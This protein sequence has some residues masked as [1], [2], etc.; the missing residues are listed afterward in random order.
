MRESMTTLL[1]DWH[2]AG[3]VSA[4]QV[5][6]IVRFERDRGGTEPSRRT[7][8]AEAVGYVG[9]AL[10]MGAI[11]LLVGEFW[12]QFTTLA[13]L[14]LV[15][16]LTF[17]LFGAGSALRRAARPPLQRLA[18]VLYAGTVAGVGWATWIV[19]GDIVDLRDVEVGIAVGAVSTAAALPLYLVRRR[20][21]PQLALLVAVLVT[22]LTTLSLPTQ[23]PDIQWYSLTAVSIGVAWFLLGA[24][25]WLPPR[26][27]AETAGALLAVFASQVTDGDGWATLLLG[28]ALAAALVV[29]AIRADALHLLAVGA[30][31]LFLILP[32][33][34]FTWFGDAIGA[35]ATMLVVGLLLVLLAVGLGRARREM[36]DG[37]EPPPPAS[38]SARKVA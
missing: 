12:Q 38:S 33:L 8:A 31:G 36:G 4:D 9:A 34:V 22:A 35:P 18:S 19:A 30:V 3:L 11:A 27:V 17:A 29:L 10:A 23:A 16:V 15:L 25:G 20:A 13:R 32:R 26:R 24:G 5:A 14:V 6:A 2:A 1:Q 21:L 7:V 28:V 37:A